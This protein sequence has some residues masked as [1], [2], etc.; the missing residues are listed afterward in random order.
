MPKAAKK[1][2]QH[3]E[4]CALLRLTN[5]ELGVVLLRDFIFASAHRRG[6]RDPI[7][8]D[9]ANRLVLSLQMDETPDVH[10]AEA[11]KALRLAGR[12]DFEAAGRNIRRRIEKGLVSLAMVRRLQRDSQAHSTSA[13]ALRSEAGKIVASLSKSDQSNKELWDRFVAKLGN[14]GLHPRESNS[15]DLYVYYEVQGRAKRMSFDSFASMLARARNKK[16]LT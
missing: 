13:S 14:R 7:P 4:I 10:D 2:R 5:Y 6:L 1:A 8:L 12:G 3:S 9:F 15:G 16:K 11:E